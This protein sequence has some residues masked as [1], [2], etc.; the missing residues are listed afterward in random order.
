MKYFF[1]VLIAFVFGKTSA[2][3][4]PNGSAEQLDEQCYQ[5]TPAEEDQ[6]GTMWNNPKIDLNEPFDT[7]VQVMMG[8]EDINGGDGIV[9]VFQPHSLSVGNYMGHMAYEF[10]TN[11]FAVEIDT[12]QNIEHNDPPYDHLAIVREGIVDHQAPENLAG[13]IQANPSNPNIEDCQF[14]SLRVFWNPDDQELRVYWD[15]E[16][17]LSYAGN[18]IND[19]FNGNS[20][21]FWGFTGGTSDVVNQQEVCID[22]GFDLALLEDVTLCPGGEID[23]QAP[24][25]GLFYQWSPDHGLS[26]TD[27]PNPTARPDSTTTYLVKITNECGEIFQDDITLILEG[28]NVDLDFGGADTIAC[29]GTSLT[30]DATHPNSSYLWS[31]GSQD[32]SINISQSGTYAVTLT[33]GECM[34]FEK[35]EVNFISPPSINLGLDT[36]LCENNSLLLNAFS[37]HAEYLW[38]DGSQQPEFEVTEPGQYEVTLSNPCGTAQDNIEINFGS[39][40]EVYLPNAFSPNGDGVNDYFY[41]QTSSRVAEVLTIQIFN[42]WGGIVFERSNLLPNDISS[43]W[44]GKAGNEHTPIGVYA[45]RLEVLLVNGET[46]W[47]SGDV[48]LLR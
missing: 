34:A 46:N 40:N 3:L 6:A 15:C 5:L 18:I 39:C 28:T 31:N 44:N 33:N 47:F 38:Q 30:L 35:V 21:V 41:V 42:R 10:I 12:Y 20:E 2:Q 19:I 37:A 48:L 26:A 45:Y 23:L 25:E 13:P 16:F 14:H 4:H 24:I 43:G 1:I 9:F 11:T 27:I 29:E 36:F 17:R 32:P 22:K 7:T 8:C